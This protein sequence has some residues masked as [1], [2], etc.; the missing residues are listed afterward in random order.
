MLFLLLTV[1]G[2]KEKEARTDGF[3]IPIKAERLEDM[4]VPR[5]AHSLFSIGEEV[6]AVGGHT[7]GFRLERSAEVLREGKW[8]PLPEPLYTHD[9]AFCVPLSNGKILI[10]GGCAEDFGIGQTWGVEI[11]DP[12]SHSFLAFGIMDRKR[13]YASALQ[14]Q[15]GSIVILGNWYSKDSWAV[16]DTLGQVTF[17]QPIQNAKRT[18][19]LFETSE[20]DVIAATKDTSLLE[21]LSGKTFNQKLL[22]E[23]PLYTN[24]TKSGKYDIGPLS[25]L[26]PAIHNENGSIGIMKVQ[27]GQFSLLRSDRKI[28]QKGIFDEPIT[29]KQNLYTDPLMRCAWLLGQGGLKNLYILKI[30]YDQA[31]D[32]GL[33]VITCYYS[34]A[35]DYPIDESYMTTLPGGRIILAGGRTPEQNNFDPSAVTWLFHT[36]PRTKA[37]FHWSWILVFLLMTATIL[38]FWFRRKKPAEPQ[39]EV[40][41]SKEEQLTKRIV[42]LM[43]KEEYFRRKGITV[44]DVATELG[45]NKSYVSVLTNLYAG[46]PFNEWINSYRVEYAA[47]LL[48]EKP[49]MRLIDVAEASG[50]S[51]ESSF[52]RIFKAA[53]G[54]TPAEYRWGL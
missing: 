10:G 19:F 40:P 29:W 44:A 43:E 32:G 38:Q 24:L 1:I 52:F 31:L 25:Y 22:Q 50:F 8:Y 16:L 15:D 5:S 14:R 21:T 45:T 41:Q 18:P 12:A 7:T 53:K 37:E 51:G 17:E 13:T 48:K 54:K 36:E 39:P 11:Y 2:C 34:P 46:K 4:S 27:N 47:R 26:V 23:W 3:F 35:D 20:G 49:G 6:V 30:D 28:P 9:G 42:D 33:A